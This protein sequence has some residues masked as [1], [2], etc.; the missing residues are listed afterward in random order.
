MGKIYR[1]LVV[2]QD[3]S[4]LG[5]YDHRNMSM[6]PQQR[7]LFEAASPDAGRLLAYA[8]GEVA[9]TL[10]AAVYAEVP[11]RV[12]MGP[13]VTE[14]PTIGV[15]S[16]ADAMSE[17]ITED[18]PA[19]AVDEPVSPDQPAAAP[20]KRKRRTKAEIEADK[21]AA[22]LTSTQLPTT[23]ST[24]TMPPAPAADSSYMTPDGPVT[25]AQTE[26]VPAAPTEPVTPALVGDGRGG[27]S[28][29]WNPF[30]TK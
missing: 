24:V 11:Q 28:Q 8:P 13:V 7:V 20:V 6:I 17:A 3:D 25:A 12:M 22:G 26:S 10:T 1:V 9:T 30:L 5:D 18:P 21:A 2:E 19:Q 15:P 29:P 16:E 4:K 23:E 14:A 27:D